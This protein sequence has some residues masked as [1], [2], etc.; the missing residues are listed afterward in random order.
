M[1][2]S[3]GG[4][5]AA[6]G[7][8]T[9]P[10]EVLTTAQQLNAGL[11]M[12]T[13]QYHNWK[14]TLSGALNDKQLVSGLGVLF[15]FYVFYSFFNTITGD[16]DVDSVTCQCPTNH[17][18]YY[19]AIVYLSISIWT[20]I[21]AS[22]AIYDG[23]KLYKNPL[24]GFSPKSNQDGDD[25][26]NVDDDDNGENGENPC[27]ICGISI[28]LRTITKSCRTVTSN[29]APGPEETTNI[30][31]KMDNQL[32]HYENHFWLEFYK[33]YSV[34]A[35]A[36]ESMS[37]PNIKS[38]ILREIQ[39][40]K[41]SNASDT[42]NRDGNTTKNDQDDGT[43][44]SNP[45]DNNNEENNDNNDGGTKNADQ[46][47][48]SENGMQELAKQSF[49]FFYPFLVIVRF[50]A[51]LALIP[52]LILQMLNTYAWICLTEDHYCEDDESRY[53]LGLAQTY[54]TFTFYIALLIA[55]LSTI[56]LRWFPYSKLARDIK[57][58]SFA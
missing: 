5:S 26:D 7:A 2:T 39:E 12:A 21:F 48:G 33:A 44:S 38:V 15:V 4:Q 6:G 46:D 20:V 32:K 14:Q 43:D 13:E 1:A 49:F 58:A 40:A 36:Y 22:I 24:S 56:M 50:F 54:L 41:C 18:S 35:G 47:D 10:S 3:I 17:R 51:Q 57:A 28:Y 8:M 16:K 53:Q 23:Y 30:Y 29:K 25:D 19:E 45:S 52:V 27:R 11:Q 34:G 9:I 42:R 31:S 37:L 55:I